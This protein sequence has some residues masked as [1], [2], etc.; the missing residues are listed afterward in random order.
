ME[1]LLQR[2]I[3]GEVSEEERLKVASWL[4]ESPEN[5]REFL[6]LRKL[7]DLSLWQSDTNEKYSVRK[8]HF[9]IQKITIELLKIAAIFLVGFWGSKQLLTQ[10][11]D[12]AQMQTIHVPAGQRAEVTLA[13]GTHVWLNSR[14]T[15]K[16]SEQFSANTRNVE[17][18]GEGY[19][20][21]QHNEKSPFTVQ[22]PKYTIQVLGTEFNVN[23]ARKS[24]VDDNTARMQSIKQLGV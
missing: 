8:R 3:R 12:K 21:V 11:P 18:D 7:Y 23:A 1:Q 6:A 22:T 17:L 24:K 14:S 4:D 9:S 10:Q 2:Y 5:M 16:F 13:D 19:F 20:S 15:L